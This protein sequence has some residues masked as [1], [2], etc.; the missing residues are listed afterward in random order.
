MLVVFW[1]LLIR[2]QTKRQKEHQEMVASLKKGDKVVTN[3]GIY[4]SVVGVSDKVVVLRVADNVKLE[5]AKQCV[6][7]LQP[8]KP[9]E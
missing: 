1:F 9:E 3:G 8:T 7:S 2:P 4:G 5:V 6:A